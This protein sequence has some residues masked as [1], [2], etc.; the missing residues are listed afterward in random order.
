MGEAQRVPR[1]RVGSRKQGVWKEDP[2]NSPQLP[3]R[4]LQQG[5]CQWAGRVGVKATPMSCRPCGGGHCPLEAW[6][7]ILV[8]DNMNPPITD[9]LHSKG[10]RF[11]KTPLPTPQNLPPAHPQGW[12]EAGKKPHPQAW[13]ISV[14]SIL[15]H[16]YIPL[17]LRALTSVTHLK[18][19]G[20]Q[21]RAAF[22]GGSW[23]S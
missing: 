7:P 10:P 12:E 20:D 6:T 11:P 13:Q 5:G 21:N 23:Q 2:R 9:T 14:Q 16:I 4:H 8:S 19:H 1:W 3:E 18:C 22:R 17:S 15:S